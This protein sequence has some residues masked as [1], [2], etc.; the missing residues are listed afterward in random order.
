MT[1][2][3]TMLVMVVASG[4]L[5]EAWGGKRELFIFFFKH[6]FFRER[7][8]VNNFQEN[9]F[10]KNKK[11]SSLPPPSSFYANPWLRTAC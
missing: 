2:M 6:L 10:L 4:K 3:N 9:I 1:Q 8:C 7:G 5:D 11:V